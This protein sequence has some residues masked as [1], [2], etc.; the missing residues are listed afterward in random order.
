MVQEFL[1]YPD[2]SSSYN[3]RSLVL[4]AVGAVLNNNKNGFDDHTK[5]FCNKHI[6]NIFPLKYFMLRKRYK[7]LA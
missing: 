4:S 6:W 7:Q 1:Q 2:A 5:S 3:V